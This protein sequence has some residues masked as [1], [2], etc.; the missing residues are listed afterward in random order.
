MVENKYRITMLKKQGSHLV[1]SVISNGKTRKDILADT[2]DIKSLQQHTW[3]ISGKAP[4]DYAYCTRC[5]VLMHRLLTKASDEYF[6]DH[7]NHTTL[8]N[9]KK[10]L[11]FATTKQNLMNKKYNTT[12]Y[13]IAGIEL[14]KSGR[15]KAH[16]RFN[17]KRK[18][19]GTYDS[20]I[21]AMLARARWEYE[22]FKEFTPR[23][24]S[25]I[26]RVPF[27]YRSSWFPEIYGINNDYFMLGDI[28]KI[29]LQGKTHEDMKRS[30]MYFR[31]EAKTYYKLKSESEASNV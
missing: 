6:V 18:H 28:T 4:Y 16:T 29:F 24:R 2:S 7:I 17:G 11:R 8:D 15:V 14:L 19:L 23:H 22:T 25:W 21:D 12:K 26:K 5:K 3:S 20:I 9:R 10:N 30:L 27:E 1:I 31:K 13:P